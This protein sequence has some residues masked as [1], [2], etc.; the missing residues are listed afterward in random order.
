MSDEDNAVQDFAS[1]R[2]FIRKKPYIDVNLS[3]LKKA[4]KYRILGTVTKVSKETFTINDGSDEIEAILTTPQQIEIKEGSLLRLFGFIEL[5]PNKQLK[6]AII[7]DMSNV[8][9]DTYNQI[10]ELEQSLYK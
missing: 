4:G 5:E 6:V 9:I 10:K 7:Q 8:D 2:Q 3:D 1:D